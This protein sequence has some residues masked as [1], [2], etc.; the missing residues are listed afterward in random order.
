MAATLLNHCTIARAQAAQLRLARLHY[1]RHVQLSVEQI[2]SHALGID[3]TALV[4]P[5]RGTRDV[6]RARHVAMYLAAVEGGLSLSACARL[7]DR[8]RRG[9]AYAVAG[10]EQRRDDDSVLD[11]LLDHLAGRLHHSLA[12]GPVDVPPDFEFT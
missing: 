8:D 5:R 11:R 4:S 6:V 1:D 12:H 3:P 7:F 9:V 2:V 10:I